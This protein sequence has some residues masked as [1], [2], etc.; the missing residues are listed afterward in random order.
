VIGLGFEPSWLETIHPQ[1]HDIPMDLIV[2]E[3]RTIRIADA[4]VR[5][6]VPIRRGAPTGPG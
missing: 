5:R 2:T 3:Q 4:S 1:S 6:M